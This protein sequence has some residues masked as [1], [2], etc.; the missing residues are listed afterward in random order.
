VP[1]QHLCPICQERVP[2]LDIDMSFPCPQ[3]GTVLAATGWGSL[4]IAQ[5]ILCTASGCL[6]MV[7]WLGLGWLGA[8]AMFLIWV[9]LDVWVWRRFIKIVLAAPGK[10]G[11]P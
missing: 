4:M 6:L 7:V 3:C 11:C 8:V 2:L 1:T 10:L 5:A 9:A